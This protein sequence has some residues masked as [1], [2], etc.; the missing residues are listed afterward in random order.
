MEDILKANPGISEVNFRI[1][2]TVRINVDSNSDRYRTE[3][4]EEERLA[5]I[6]SYKVKKKDSWSSI[7]KKTGVDVETLKEA[8]EEVALPEKNDILNIPVI[9]TVKVEKQVNDIDPRELSE[10]G[11]RELY[12]SIHKID[13][14]LEQ[15]REVRVAMLLDDPV[16][17]KRR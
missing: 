2:D 9:E 12:D 1:G 8:N 13:S 6:D 16:S 5:S 4:V 17:K 7:S 10:D 11:I 15:L 3:L 14:G